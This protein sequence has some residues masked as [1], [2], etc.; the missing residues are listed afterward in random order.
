MYYLADVASC[1]HQICRYRPVFY[2]FFLNAHQPGWWLN[3]RLFEG[4]GRQDTPHFYFSS[5]FDIFQHETRRTL[6]GPQQKE[7]I[8]LRIANIMT[9]LYKY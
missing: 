9:L 6:S 1:Q 3:R 7:D 4:G 8:F 5:F 2:H